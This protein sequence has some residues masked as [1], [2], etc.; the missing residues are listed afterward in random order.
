MASRSRKSDPKGRKVTVAEWLRRTPA[1]CIPKGARVRT[2]AVTALRFCFY[3]YVLLLV[4]V[5][6]SCCR[7]PMVGSSLWCHAGIRK[8]T[9]WSMFA[10]SCLWQ[11]ALRGR[12]GAAYIDI[13]SNV[14]MAPLPPNLVL[15]KVRTGIFYS[16][17]RT[18]GN[19]HTTST[20]SCYMLS[21]QMG[22]LRSCSGCFHV[23]PPA[24][25]T[26]CSPKQADGS[27][28]LRASNA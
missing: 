25:S 18:K 8:D 12:P 19:A 3:R 26:R 1:K 9:G 28:A 27:P 23:R 6:H 17:L 16:E 14:L 21:Q 2:S 22:L 15:A 24:V 11:A 7:A 20:G 5:Q 13:P 4:V 10:F